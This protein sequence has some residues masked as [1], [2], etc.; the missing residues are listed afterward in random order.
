MN[1]DD[2]EKRV[3]ELKAEAERLQASMLAM[4]RLKHCHEHGHNLSVTV[5]EGSFTAINKMSVGCEHC[6]ASADID[7]GAPL[8]LAEGSPLYGELAGVRLHA[9][10]FPSPNPT[11]TNDIPA[12]TEAPPVEQEQTP[13]GAYRVDVS[14]I[15]GTQED[16]ENE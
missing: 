8:S 16:D 14:T 15:L 11:E 3:E 10:D 5:D 2:Y 9:I 12:Q 1:M 7:V 6:G 13:G 4:S